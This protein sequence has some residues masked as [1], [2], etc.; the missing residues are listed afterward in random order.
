MKWPV[1]KGLNLIYKNGQI[2]H[3]PSVLNDPTIRYLLNHTHELEVMGKYLRQGEG[4]EA[5]YE[6]YHSD[7]FDKYHGFLESYELLKP[8]TRFEESDIKVLMG[9]E[10]GMEN[11]DLEEIRRQIIG[12]EESVRGVS[13]MFFKHEKY[14]LRKDALIDAV[15]QMLNITSLADDRDQQY[16]YVLE[17]DRPKCIVLCENIDFLKRPTLSRRHDIEL[18]YAGGRNISKLDYAA[19]AT[20][21]LP[22]F[23]SCDWD[24][25]G[26]EIFES[27]LNKIPEIKL[28]NPNSEPYSLK[29]SEHKSLWNGKPLSG[30]NAAL[31]NDSQKELISRLIVNE[32]W[33]MEE[34]NNLILMVNE[35]IGEYK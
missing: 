25:D 22:V 2:L 9:I 29:D 3:K 32:E 19:A 35:K 34:A 10:R 6:K 11:G 31:Y 23:Y 28:L 27:V 13:R 20:R 7:N 16:K 33:I 26:L 15:K 17:C 18:W 21:D 4:F 24:R 12:A 14:L 1:L 8:Q 5:Y 30:L